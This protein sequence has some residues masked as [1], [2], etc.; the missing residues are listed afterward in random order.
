[1]A[2][3]DTT[4]VEF[5][6]APTVV[7]VAPQP[8]R[9]LALKAFYFSSVNLASVNIQFTHN[10]DARG[11]RAIS[12]GA[13]YGLR[14]TSGESGVIFGLGFQWARTGP[15]FYNLHSCVFSLTGS[16]GRRTGYVLGAN[17]EFRHNIFREAVLSLTVGL[18]YAAD[19]NNAPSAGASAGMGLM[20]GMH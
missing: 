14:R 15:L 20:W 1:M 11:I 6:V 3:S 2:Q 5:V 17:V 16:N 13:G 7:S 19:G 12:I 4:D 9:F 10:L 18:N 8:D